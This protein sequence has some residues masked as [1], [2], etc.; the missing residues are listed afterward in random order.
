MPI[1]RASG[2]LKTGW[3]G[4]RIANTLNPELM[5]H[6][7]HPSSSKLIGHRPS[8]IGSITGKR[9]SDELPSALCGRILVQ[10]NTNHAPATDKHAIQS[11]PKPNQF[12]PRSLAS[13]I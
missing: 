7:A 9:D 13:F 5:R 11:I 8:G 2:W 3:K 10:S 12:S 4:G 1:V 6:Q